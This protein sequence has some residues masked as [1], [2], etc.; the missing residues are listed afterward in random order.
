MTEL[1]FV[2]LAVGVLL[3]IDF[4]TIAARHSF[5]QTSHAR[6]LSLRETMERQVNRAAPLLGRLPRLRASLNLL[7]VLIRFLLAGLVLFQV[8]RQSV[9]ASFGVQLG[10]IL[11]SGLLVFWF[12]G[13]TERAIGRAPELWALRLTPYVIA[14]MALVGWLLLPL[15]LSGESQQSSEISGNVT[16]D[17]IKNLVDAGQEEGVFELGER[18]MIYSVFQLSETLVREIMIPRI[19]MLALDV[20]TPLVEAIDALLASG[21]SRVPVYE[22]TVDKTLGVLYSKDLL[23]VLRENAQSKTIRELLR[24]AYF[25]PEAKKVDEL[26]A[27]MQSQRIHIALVV[28]E[29]GG[30]AGLVTLEDIVEEI[31]GEIQDEFDQGEES[32]YTALKNGEYLFSGRID[33]NDFNEIM[34]SNLPKE[35]S[36][37]LA[38]FIYNQ[39]GRVPNVGDVV[40]KDNL[41]LTV[42]QVSARRIRKVRARRATAVPQNGE[43]TD[44]NHG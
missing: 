2:F 22:E 40:E 3:V 44:E 17:E 16:E 34:N 35:D 14:V 30:V 31:V 8:S 27:E 38:G 33:L 11:V 4:A 39:I 19:D 26:L 15:G 13:A 6:L 1:A 5:S 24:P 23:G 29:Y 28:D 10:A 20:N 37:T 18:Q 41:V 36:E 9:A 21:H 12:E 7:L 32:P 43:K 42:E 25:V